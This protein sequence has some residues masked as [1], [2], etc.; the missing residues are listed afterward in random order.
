MPRSRKLH[1]AT[2]SKTARETSWDGS[3]S[4]S[5]GQETRTEPYVAAGGGLRG[6]RSVTRP[7]VRAHDGCRAPTRGA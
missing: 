7:R 2:E 6:H 5:F 4:S 1:K 3:A